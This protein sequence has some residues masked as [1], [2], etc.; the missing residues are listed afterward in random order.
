MKTWVH[1][2][3]FYARRAVAAMLCQIIRRVLLDTS[4]IDRLSL[5]ARPPWALVPVLM[6]HFDAVHSRVEHGQNT[7]TS[8][9]LL[10]ATVALW[11]AKASVLAGLVGGLLFYKP[12]LAALLTTMVVLDLRGPA[13]AGGVCEPSPV[14]C[15]GV[16]LCTLPGYPRASSIRCPRTCISCRTKCRISGNGM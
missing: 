3:T 2:P 16:I 12:Q 13:Y 15:F 10:T 6:V 4:L 14:R 9:L 5:G 8:L 11:R 7:C 1:L